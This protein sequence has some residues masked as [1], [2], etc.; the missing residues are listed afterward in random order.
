MTEAVFFAIFGISN[1]T[2]QL[3][4]GMFFLATAWGAYFV[5]RLWLSRMVAFA[6]VLLFIGTPVMVLWGRQV[7]LEIPTFAFLLWSVYF[8]F[9]Y[10]ESHAARYMYLATI[11]VLAACFTKQ[12]AIFIVPAYLWTLLTIYKWQ[13]FRKAAFWW[14]AAIIAIG[15]SPLVLYT[16]LWG[17]AN[18]HQAV[19]GGWV[20]HSRL[21]LST[22]SYVARFEWPRQLGWT[23]LALA[24]VYCVGCLCRKAWRPAKPA[25]SFLLAWVVMGYVF[26][27]LIAVSSQRYTIFLVFPLVVFSI[28]SIIRIVPTSMAAYATLAFAILS[29]FY[30]LATNHVPYVSGYRAAAEYV[31]SVAPPDSVVMFSGL[32]DGSFIFNVKSMPECKNL[33]VIRAD[34][35]LLRVAIHRSLFGVQEFGVSEVKF[36]D[37]LE[38]YGVRFIVIEPDFWPDLKSMQMLSDMLHQDQFRLLTTIP[39]SSNRER[40][41][42]NLEIY[43]NLGP[44]SVGKNTLRVE[45]PVSGI[46]VQGPVGQS[47]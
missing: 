27:T 44:L 28:L 11:M 47:R 41:R 24:I 29:F 3:T 46:A 7:M 42:S 9:R 37:M 25:L 1:A 2:A 40:I 45:L 38:R 22:W 15:M 34:K 16:W 30:T 5:C 33:T 20:K 8:F 31:C 32:R 18:M 19:G 13:L 23:I 43:E 26:F 21:S 6:T 35:L 12:P 17:R 10:L 36:R 39:I 14:S 4:V